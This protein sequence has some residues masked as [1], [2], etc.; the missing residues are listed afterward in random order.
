MIQIFI[1]LDAAGAG[2]AEAD[3]DTGGT[4]RYGGSGSAGSVSMEA[5]ASGETPASIMPASS[6]TPTLST[7]LQATKA[8]KTKQTIAIFFISP[9]FYQDF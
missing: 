4:A 3:T 7:D 9:L 6:V 8:P 2:T 5:E 1:Y